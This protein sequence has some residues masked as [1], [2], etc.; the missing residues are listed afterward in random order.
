MIA[1]ITMKTALVLSGG[2]ARGAYQ[3]GVLKGIAE[4]F[5]KTDINPFQIICGTSSGAINAAKLACE[6]DQFHRSVQGLEEI[7]SSL[8]SSSVHQADYW[9]II[10]SFSRV[11]A[12]FFHSGIARGRS[13][14]LFNNAPL[15]ELLRRNV[16]LDRL[17]VMIAEQYIHALCITAL[18]YASGHNIGFFQGHRSIESWRSARRIG[19]RTKLGYKHLLASSALPGIF[20]AVRINREY[21]GD[22]ALRQT[23]PMSAALHLGADKL[24]VIGVSGNKRID[25]DERITSMHSPTMAQVLGQLLNSAF[26]DAQEED[27]EMLQRFNSFIGFIEPEE[28]SRLKV[29]AVDVLVI[30]PSIKFDQL[31]LQYIHCLPPAMRLL[32]RIIG[33]NSRGG[34]SSLASYLLF[35]KEYCE[36]L[37][38]NG[39]KDAMDQAEEIRQFVGTCV[40]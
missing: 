24:L 7:W 14:S 10:K 9:D 32:L 2:G 12:S 25:K 18:G 27:V 20:P 15:A 23:A 17:D 30:S 33:A 11:F 38:E 34:G 35:E 28:R 5:P 39:Y 4:L 29:R 40:L 22:G 19:L 26:I 1:F 37:I 21:F 16:D 31:A 3:V 13:L 8:S 6:A 36:A